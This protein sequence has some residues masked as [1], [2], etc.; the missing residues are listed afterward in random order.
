M[1][2]FKVYFYK[3]KRG[4]CPHTFKSRGITSKGFLVQEDFVLGGFC[5]EEFCPTMGDPIHHK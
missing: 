3:F 1:R 4:F 2:N 5:P